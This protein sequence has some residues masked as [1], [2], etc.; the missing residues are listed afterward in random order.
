MEMGWFLEGM[1]FREEI[2]GRGRLEERA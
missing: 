1:G 2:L